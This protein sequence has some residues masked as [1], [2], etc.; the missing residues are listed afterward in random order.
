[1]SS[2][3]QRSLF[4]AHP[5]KFLYTTWFL[6]TLPLRLLGILIYYLPNF[7]RSHPRRSYR[8][9]VTTKL[10]QTWFRFATAV[11]YRTPKSLQPGADKAQFLLIDSADIDNAIY[12]GVLT[13]DPAIRPGPIAGFWY[14]DKTPPKCSDM[15]SLVAL[16]FH[17]GAFVLGGARPPEGGWGS[18]VMSKHMDCPVLLVQY[19]LSSSQEH[20]CFPAAL[21][22]VVTAYAYVLRVLQVRPENIVLSGDSAGGNLV[23]ALLRYIEENSTLLPLPRA[24]LLWGPWVNVDEPGKQMDRHRNVPTDYIFGDLGDWGVRSYTPAGWSSSHPYITPLG[25]E[26]HTKVP[27]FIQTGTAEMLYDSHLLFAKNMKEHGCKVE[28]F[29]IANA[30]HDTFAGGEFLGFR[31]EAEDAIE[32]AAMFVKEAGEHG[33]SGSS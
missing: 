1:M 33:I 19:R 25:N 20:T 30:P 18:A 7:T 11:E 32:R 29:E 10:I 8:Q 13:N 9:A 22:D 28:L 24:A 2:R 3:A 5:F 31:K 23:V 17:G 15:P 4:S 26:F 16:H 6:A 14:G 27:I 12:T 21:Q